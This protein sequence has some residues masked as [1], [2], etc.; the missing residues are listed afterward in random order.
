MI[1]AGKYKVDIRFCSIRQTLD[2]HAY[3]FCGCSHKLF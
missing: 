3:T 1:R 2:A